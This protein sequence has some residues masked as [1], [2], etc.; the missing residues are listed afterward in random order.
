MATWSTRIVLPL[1]CERSCAVSE[2][3]DQLCQLPGLLLQVEQPLGAPASRQDRGPGC[4]I[5]LDPIEVVHSENGAPLVLIAEEAKA[6]G[7]PGLLVPHQV[8]VDDLPIPATHSEHR[9]QRQGR[10]GGGGCGTYCEN[11]QMTSPS[12]SS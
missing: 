4:L 7:L 2:G 9:R 12:V 10:G 1:I 6:F 8:D 5:H 11:T 3:T